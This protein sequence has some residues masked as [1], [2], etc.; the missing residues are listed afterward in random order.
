M[1]SSKGCPGCFLKEETFTCE[2]KGFPSGSEGKASACDAEDPG[3]IPGSGRSPGEGN[4]NPLQYSCLE[5]PMDRGAW[6]ATVHGVAKSWTWWSNWLHLLTYRMSRGWRD[7]DLSIRQAL[8]QRSSVGK[9]VSVW[10]RTRKTAVWQWGES[11]PG[12]NW[13]WNQIGHRDLKGYCFY[14]V[15]IRVPFWEC[16]EMKKRRVQRE[17]GRQT[18]RQRL[19][20]RVN[21]CLCVCFQNRVW[22]A[23]GR[24]LRGW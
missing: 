11:G 21:E 12:C 16:G 4:G 18:M 15:S 17:R 23:S 14:P 2:L 10:E 20:V 22:I 9:M 13:G 5:N 8:D 24:K 19:C 1:T 6:W 7:K 3:S